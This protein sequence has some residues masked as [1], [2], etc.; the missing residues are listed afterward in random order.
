MPT[1]RTLM[2]MIVSIG[3]KEVSSG[4]I[5]HTPIEFQ[6][7]VFPEQPTN[8][9]RPW[10]TTGQVQGNINTL[11]VAPQLDLQVMLSHQK[12]TTYRLVVTEQLPGQNVRGIVYNQ[13]IVFDDRSIPDAHGRIYLPIINFDLA[14]AYIDL[15]NRYAK[16]KSIQIAFTSGIE[17]PRPE[18]KLV[19]RG[20]SG[21][22]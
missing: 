18:P 9:P 7:I 6:G 15:P 10:I 13:E 12:E 2:Y 22:S 8:L 1:P 11:R 3:E 19:K 14:A 17:R 20:K 5:R 21:A 16:G 4:Y